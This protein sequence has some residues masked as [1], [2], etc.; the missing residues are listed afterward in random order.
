MSLLKRQ[1]PVLLCF[2]TGL[3]FFLQYYVPH[4][5]SQSLLTEATVWVAIVGGFSLLLGLVS[6]LRGHIGKLLN[7]QAGWGYSLV[8]LAGLA[9]M[10]GIGIWS[11]NQITDPDSG[12][13]T[14][15]GWAYTY[16]LCPLNATMF[17]TLGFF[18]ASAA[19]RTFRLKSFEAG[20]LMAAALIV[21]FGRVPLGEFLWSK[22]FHYDAL[23][24]S[25]TPGSMNA[26][27]EWIVKVPNMAARR[28]ILFGVTLGAIATSLKVIL[29]L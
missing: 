27:T 23:K 14:P 28:G 15:F 17:A 25:Q 19:F 8:L 18:V 20:L 26:I 9:A 7:L 11:R 24:A 6:V 5:Y 1:L 13:I 2:L 21:I 29:G 4:P 3:V 10:L 16:M 12:R 22:L